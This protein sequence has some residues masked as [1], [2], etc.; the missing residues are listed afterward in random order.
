MGVEAEFADYVAVYGRPRRL[1]S[2]EE[3]VLE[4]NVPRQWWRTVAAV[5]A[6]NGYAAGDIL[7]YE[8]MRCQTLNT[9]TADYLTVQANLERMRALASR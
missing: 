5:G 7:P 6:G 4:V 8:Y 2:E 9:Q 3:F 1:T